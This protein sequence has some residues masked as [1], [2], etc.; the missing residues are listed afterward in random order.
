MLSFHSMDSQIVLPKVLGDG[1]ILQRDENVKIWGW[2][3]KGEPITV[4][5]NKKKYKVTT[6]ADGSWM[7]RVATG[8]AGGPFEMKIEGKNKILLNNILVGDVY[9]CAGQSNM[10]HQMQLH[11]IRYAEDIAKADNTK[12]RQFFVPNVTSLTAPQKDF[13][14]GAWKTATKENIADFSAVAYFFAKKLYE[15]YRVPIGIINTSWGGTPIESWISESGFKDFPAAK[16]LI[17]KNKDTAYIAAQKTNYNGNR[18]PEQEDKGKTGKWYANAYVPKGWRPIAVPG[19]WE[20]QGVRDLD[21]VVWYRREI[22]VPQAMAAG[23]AK[24]FMGR[25]VDADEVYI[26][27]K[28]IGHTTYLYPQRRYAIPDGTLQAGKNTIVVRI[29]NNGG[30]GGFVP[31]KPYYLTSNNDTIDL[32]GYWQYKVG[33]VN[34]PVQRQG[35]GGGINLQN[36]PTALYNAMVAPITNYGIKGIVWY[37]GESNTGKA[38]EYPKLQEALV[39]DWRT[40][41]NKELPFLYVQLP[42]FM[43]YRYLPSDSQ[44]ALFREAQA[45]T[46]TLPKTAMAVAI[47]LG[48]WNDIHPDRKK[49]VGE[50]LAIAAQKTIYGEKIVAA[51]P[52]YKSYTADGNKLV[53]TFTNADKGLLTTDGEAPEEFAIAGEDKKFVWAKA[54]IDGNKIVLWNDEIKEPKYV[55][56]AWADNPVNPNLVNTENL[57]AAPF[58]TDK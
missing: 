9:V 42:G 22:D 54:K 10:V 16:E 53:V 25:I 33:R 43:D 55:R 39:A 46:L 17:A 11:N 57:P 40:K 26:N 37:Q 2:A 29:T 23:K 24:I 47:D 14:Q 30:K 35:G 1:M 15:K 4:T 44:W 21:G 8:K 45:A 5:F 38:D 6:N 56:Y 7:I 50:R 20:D 41:W 51:G 27:G 32:T 19:Y 28:E 34:I 31:D 48:E 13:N 58:R 36:Q 12:I 18:Q 3:S 52:T 49:E